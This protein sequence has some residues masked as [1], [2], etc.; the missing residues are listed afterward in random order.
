MSELCCPQCGLETEVFEEGYCQ[1]CNEENYSHIYAE[2][3]QRERW[4]RMDSQERE[5]EIR[6][7][8]LG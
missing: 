1:P 6:Q 7:A 5:Y 8:M 3:W 2:N 4:L